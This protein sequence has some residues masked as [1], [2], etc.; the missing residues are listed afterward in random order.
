MKV[1]QANKTF[2][3]KLSEIEADLEEIEGLEEEDS[4]DNIAFN[5]MRLQD[6]LSYNV[7]FEEIS[8]TLEQDK[9]GF[10]QDRSRNFVRILSDRFDTI[11]VYKFTNNENVAEAKNYINE[12]KQNVCN[13]ILSHLV[14]QYGISYNQ[15][16]VNYSPDL[17]MIA[18]IYE[19]FIL[20][21][22]ENI[23]QYLYKLLT[24]LDEENGVSY[25]ETTDELIQEIQR[26]KET[27]ETIGENYLEYVILNFFKFVDILVKNENVAS[28]IS[29]YIFESCQSDAE[30]IT[31]KKITQAYYNYGTENG[32]DFH[33]KESFSKYF[34]LL[35]KPE[36][37]NEVLRSLFAKFL[38][39]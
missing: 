35:K 18:E 22:K 39:G 31:N 6:E 14:D 30:E 9:V 10:I 21:K 36:Y 20:R 32:L 33:D 1:I 23:S 29:N 8:D 15:N 34:S 17:E 26:A 7:L 13:L 3:Q 16:L 5:I 11:N 2:K 24:N 4:V 25:R 28:S 12:L 38:K 37:A 27:K 19:F